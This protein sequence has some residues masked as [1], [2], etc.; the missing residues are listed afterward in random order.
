MMSSPPVDPPQHDQFPPGELRHEAPG[1]EFMVE[2]A[3]AFEL[4]DAEEDAVEHFQHLAELTD[5]EA[6]DHVDDSV[7]TDQNDGESQEDKSENK[8]D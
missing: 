1:I 4:S 8:K 7:Y 2:D 6:F 5:P 3:P